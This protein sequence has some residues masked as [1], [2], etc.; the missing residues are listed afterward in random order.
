MKPA[1]RV[2]LLSNFKDVNMKASALSL[3][4]I[5][6]FVNKTGIHIFLI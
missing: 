2:S 1:S 4:G 5:S 3:S 6:A